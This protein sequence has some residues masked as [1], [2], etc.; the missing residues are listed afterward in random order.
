M[1]NTK[2]SNLTGAASVTDNSVF[3]VVD[4]G[5]TKKVTGTQIRTYARS[6]LST[7]AVSGS[8]ADLTNKP[9]IFDGNYNNLTNKPTL[10]NG[11]YASLTGKPTLFD[12][13]YN[14][15]SNKPTLF[16]GSYNS[17]TDTP[18]LFD[19]NFN[20]LTN[21][22]TVPTTT[23]QLTNDSG[24]ITLADVPS[25]GGVTSYNDLTD[26][27][28]I[29][30]SLSDLGITAGSDGQVLKLNSS[31]TPVWSTP[32]GTGNF[33]FSGSTLTSPTDGVIVIPNTDEY[34]GIRSTNDRGR[35]WFDSAN[36]FHLVVDNTYQHNFN[37]DGS[38]SFGGGYTFPNVKGTSGQV[39]VSDVSG[40]LTW[41]NQ[42]S[43]GAGGNPF[44]Q[45][46]NTTNNVT[47]GN[48]T[49]SYISSVSDMEIVTATGSTGGIDLYTD[50]TGHGV[51]VWLQ[52]NDRVSIKTENGAY[53]WSFNNVGNLVLPQADMTASPAPVLSGIVF[54]DGTFQNTAA[55]TG[56]TFNQSL[57]TTDGPSF[58]GITINGTVNY[59]NGVIQRSGNFV[60]CSPNMDT[61]VYTGLD[62]FQTLKLLFNIE[63][64]EDG[65]SQTDTQSCEMIVAK[66]VRNN[67]VSG[68][69]YGLVY[70]STNPLVTLSTRWNSTI[71]RVEILCRPTSTMNTVSVLSTCT[72]IF[73]ASQY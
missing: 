50:W 64:V 70:T 57:N 59:S 54:S 36:T 44:N 18:I 49:T 10:F 52:H 40:N 22:P 66:S 6:G 1:A 28:S 15:L 16:N 13:D 19:G 21:K 56:S 23:S 62:T 14:S 42:A 34:A 12:G 48:V 9:T 71:N 31:L 29:P 4:S 20:S 39:L 55:T 51:E 72:E 65:Q 60:T 68:S 73:S 53:E 3:P 24:F 2:I 67:T 37:A 7:V 61:V 47:F 41:Q 11:A 8:Y 69:A 25:G 33:T 43:G 35:M 5:S 45:D 63:G 46:L 30:S 32:A 17:L 58:T 38:I 26:K 27:P